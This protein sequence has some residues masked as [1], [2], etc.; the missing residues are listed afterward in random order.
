MHLQLQLGGKNKNKKNTNNKNNKLNKNKNHN[1]NYNHNNNHNQHTT[2]MGLLKLLNDPNPSP[3]PQQVLCVPQG[4]D[5][6]P[7]RWRQGQGH[8]WGFQGP[9]GA[10]AEDDAQ[11]INGQGKKQQGVQ[12]TG[13]GTG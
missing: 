13:A 6:R 8:R 1:H 10:Q 3:R 5:Q 4:L 2:T 11:G 9:L 7:G 12:T